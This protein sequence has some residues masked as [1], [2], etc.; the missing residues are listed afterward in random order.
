LTVE[1]V[2]SLFILYRTT[3]NTK[4]Q[5]HAWSI[6]Q[7]IEKSCKTQFGYS[8]LANV[9]DASEG[10]TDHM[11][12]H[13][14]AETLKYLYLIFSPPEQVSLDEYLFNTQGHLIRFSKVKQQ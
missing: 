3:G 5:E 12:S 11:P 13:F 2:E 9:M 6:V 7:A 14:V 1:T 4:Y 10:M 8:A